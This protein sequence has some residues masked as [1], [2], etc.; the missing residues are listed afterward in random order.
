M[1]FDTAFDTMVNSVVRSPKVINSI[2]Q[3]AGKIDKIYIVSFKF[4][5]KC[6]IV[7]Y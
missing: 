1:Q 2:K 6:N 3:N 7:C 4:H 5:I